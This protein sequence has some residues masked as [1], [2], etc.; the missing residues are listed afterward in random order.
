MNLNVAGS[1]RPYAKFHHRSGLKTIEYYQ[2]LHK[3]DLWNQLAATIYAL[4]PEVRSAVFLLYSKR[5]D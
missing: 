4:P 1:Y 5:A 3:F 2:L